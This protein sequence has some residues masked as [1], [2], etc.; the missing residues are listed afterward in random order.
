MRPRLDEVVLNTVTRT[1]DKVDTQAPTAPSNLAYTEPADGKI[2]LTW[3]ASSDDT[4]VTGYDAATRW[5]SAT[6]RSP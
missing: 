5:T 1:G 6:P 3:S 2:K 4:K